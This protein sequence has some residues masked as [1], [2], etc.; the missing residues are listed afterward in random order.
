MVACLD[1]SSVV[2]G[3]ACVISV[4]VDSFK[5]VSCFGAIDGSVTVHV[6]GG[7]P[8]PASTPLTA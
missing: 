3:N 4:D 6:N 2:I 8:P 5:D 7:I 1:T